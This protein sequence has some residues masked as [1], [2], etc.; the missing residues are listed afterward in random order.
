MVVY[1]YLIIEKLF[2][3]R[4]ISTLDVVKDYEW[5]KNW[6]IKWGHELKI[7]IQT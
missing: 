6:Y 5:I 7:L 1:K 2:E 4:E 3:K